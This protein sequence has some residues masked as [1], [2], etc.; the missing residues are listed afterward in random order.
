ML[1]CNSK[2]TDQIV[3]PFTKGMTIAYKLTLGPGASARFDVNPKTGTG[4]FDLGPNNMNLTVII[5][6]GTGPF[7]HT[8][9]HAGGT[10]D[11]NFVGGGS[12]TDTSGTVTITCV[13][14]SSGS[15]STQGSQ[16][17]SE[18]E[19]SD[20]AD[21]EN[22]K[23]AA[24]ATSRA[25]DMGTPSNHPHSLPSDGEPTDPRLEELKDRL[26]AVT[27]EIV[28][29]QDREDFLRALIRGDL[30][31]DDLFQSERDQIYKDE[32]KEL[33]DIVRRITDLEGKQDGLRTE[34]Q[35][36]SGDFTP[37]T[38]EDLGD[39]DALQYSS[40]RG[41]DIS[42]VKRQLNSMANYQP[43]MLLSNG[44][45]AGRHI[46][47][48]GFDIW[49]DLKFTALDGTAGLQGHTLA[50]RIGVVKSLTGRID[51]GLFATL[52]YGDVKLGSQA[53]ALDSRS[54]GFGGYLK[55]QV[56]DG[57]NAGITTTYQ[58]FNNDINVSG[59]TGSFNRDRY[60]VD[61]A[62]TGSY[63]YNDVVITPSAQLI[64]V[65]IDRQGYTDS[66]A[67]VVPGTSD[68]AVTAT[69]ALGL[70]QTFLSGNDRIKSYT[71][72][73]GLGINFHLDRL[74]D[75][76]FS[77]GSTIEFSS[78]SGYANAGVTVQFNNGGSLNLTGGANGL[79]GDV[80]AYHGTVKFTL[81]LQ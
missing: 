33:G 12:S 56:T 36:V 6:L 47:R 24:N 72:A 21:A 75:A 1:V 9:T 15:S 30:S 27:Q 4:S 51:G 77:D 67:T 79:G 73:V 42:E 60:T 43:F 62:L 70:S 54:F 20:T 46:R 37:D 32:R 64:W 10:A 65:H 50:G 41:A 38:L 40:N 61:A 17:G 7:T 58:R 22:K 34:I 14:A 3:V 68:S 76:V 63:N 18:T 69:A 25:V 5:R 13:P 45:R 55:T 8:Q 26:A 74:S 71:P 52:M 59:A 44:F 2:S 31:E 11:E 53:T 66:A 78:V 19:G 49:S 48:H 28:E 39:S 35:E 57:L 23:N 29:L 16:T 81:P 80:Q